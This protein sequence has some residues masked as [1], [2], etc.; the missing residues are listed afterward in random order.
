MPDVAPVRVVLDT[1]VL[2]DW[3]VFG[4]PSVLPLVTAIEAGRL[5]WLACAPM[6]VEFSRTLGYDNLAAWAPDRE[7]ALAAFDRHARL[8]PVP[9]TL[10]ALRC[11]DADDQVF[12]DL[13]VAQGCRW[14]FTHDRALH[15]LARRAARLGVQVLRPRDWVPG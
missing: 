12:L 3:L 10:P 9:S 11:R 14:L 5:A 15:Q 6:R 13:A 2:L 8:K 4:E 7:Q 1:N